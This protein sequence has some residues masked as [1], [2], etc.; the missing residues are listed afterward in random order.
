[1]PRVAREGKRNRQKYDGRP[2]AFDYHAVDF[3]FNEGT[4]TRAGTPTA[5]TVL[6]LIGSIGGSNIMLHD[7]N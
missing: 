3:A 2:H 6:D 5:P 1:M 4:D 7:E